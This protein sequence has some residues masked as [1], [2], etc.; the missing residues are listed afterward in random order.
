MH[1]LR[2]ATSAEA[3]CTLGGDVIP[4]KI[5]Q[6]VG[7]KCDLQQWTSALF[8]L[9]NVVTKSRPPKSLPVSRQNSVDGAVK[10]E[11]LKILLE[12]YLADEFVLAVLCGTI[13]SCLICRDIS[14]THVA[15]LFNSQAMNLDVL[16]VSCY[17]H[18]PYPP[19]VMLFLQVISMVPPKWPLNIMSSFLARSF[20]RRLHARHEGQ[21]KKSLYAGQKLQVFRPPFFKEPSH[22]WIIF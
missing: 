18:S 3:Y 4:G 20:R 11:L 1:D 19:P 15:R 14:A 9:P 10:K 6:T 17:T 16:D 12:V 22:R 2:D 7:E 21:I 5:A 13:Y 8:A